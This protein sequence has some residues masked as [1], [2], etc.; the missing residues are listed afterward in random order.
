MGFCVK[1]KGLYKI[2]YTY[3]NSRDITTQVD[4]NVIVGEK[5]PQQ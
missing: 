4:R 5:K 3:T 2:V 1:K